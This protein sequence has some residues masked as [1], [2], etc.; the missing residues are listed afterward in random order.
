MALD[1]I[2]LQTEVYARGF[3]Y[4]NDGGAGVTRVKRWINSAM[5]DIDEAER[6]PYLMTTTTGA[7]PLTVADLAGIE[8]IRQ[9]DII[10]APSDRQ[11]LQDKFG[12]LTTTG[13]P[14]YYYATSATTIAVY[15]VSTATLTVNYWKFAT[16]LSANGDTP[17]MPDRFRESIV[18][19]ACSIAYRDTDNVQMSAVCLGESERIVQRMRESYDL[20]LGAQLQ[21]IYGDSGD[22]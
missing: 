13:T 7:A 20:Q 4:L 2:A 3:N 15:P 8:S 5:H 6:W 18:E 16:D 1:F 11:A 22:W 10:L 9:G 21:Q 14:T 19:R 17:A 12:N